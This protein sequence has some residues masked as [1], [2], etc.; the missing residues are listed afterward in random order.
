MIDPDALS[1]PTF[2]QCETCQ[3][4]YVYS[5]TSSWVPETAEV[6]SKD[7]LVGQLAALSACG[8][9]RTCRDASTKSFPAPPAETS[10]PA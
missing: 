2:V 3:Y 6:P 8:I 10:S 7:D 5:Q 1:V 4:E 9:F